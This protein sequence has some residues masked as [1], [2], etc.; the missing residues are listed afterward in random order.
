MV[1]AKPTSGYDLDRVRTHRFN[2]TT[3]CQDC[4]LEMDGS[5]PLLADMPSCPGPMFRLI[6][7]GA[8]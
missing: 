4:R 5:G 1:V 7:V 6:Y 8:R 2:G 3:V